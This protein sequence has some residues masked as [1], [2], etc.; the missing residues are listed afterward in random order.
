MD[1]R[2]VDSPISPLQFE[3]AFRK[4]HNS[5]LQGV[6]AQI[7]NAIFGFPLALSGRLKQ[8]EITVFLK[9]YGAE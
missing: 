1:Y 2:F 5:R 7:E 6:S 9:Q 4:G 3:T 8:S